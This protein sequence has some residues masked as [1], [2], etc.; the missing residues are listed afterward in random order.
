MFDGQIYNQQKG[1]SMGITFAPP[2]SCLAVG[3]LEET[4]LFPITLPKHF[5][6]TICKIIEENYKRYM[7]DG[8]VPLPIDANSMIFLQCLN[9]LHPNLTFTLEEPTVDQDKNIQSINFLDIKIIEDENNY[10][11]TELYYKATNSHQY[12]DFRSNHP[13]H[14][15]KNI[16]MNLA[17]KIMTFNTKEEKIKEDLQ[18]L[19]KW[20]HKCNYPSEIIKKGFNKARSNSKEHK[21]NKDNIIPFVTTNYSNMDYKQVTK[22]IDNL[23]KTC[24]N[25]KLK[26]IFK[27]SKIVLSM[28]QPPNL[29]NILMKSEF[30]KDEPKKPE[31]LY[32]CTRSNCNICKLYLQEVKE[33]E[34]ADRSIWKIKCHINCRSKNVIYY[35]IC[36][37]CQEVSYIGKTTNLRQRTNQH[38][39]SSRTGRNTTDIFDIH[40]HKCG[41]DR[42]NLK[43]PF[44]KLYAFMTL[45]REENLLYHERQ[46]QLKN[47]DTMNR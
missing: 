29:K 4:K 38:I 15:K 32:K 46:L 47:L 18:N 25:D 17:K 34:C 11:T 39:S 36:N 44:F 22:K 10:I 16:P 40:V 13:T 43:E 28:K 9:D 21:E 37:C 8:I 3:Y 30:S 2:Y 41:T 12:L 35:L 42:N 6:N 31:G 14:T 24:K 45:S 7:D 27:E 20:L 19:E 5:N 33:F 23:L 26:D 1:A